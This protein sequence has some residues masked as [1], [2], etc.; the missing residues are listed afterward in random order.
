MNDM[1]EMDLENYD[2]D[3]DEL[4]SDSEHAMPERDDAEVV[5]E[6]H[7][8]SVFSVKLDPV[9]ASLAVTGGEDEKAYVWK[10]V[11]GEVLF[12]CEG[13]TSDLLYML[14]VRVCKNL[15]HGLVF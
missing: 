13:K 1:N 2:A 14:L 7:T 4:P 5:F 9:S 11:N 6:K 12:E 10:T 8:S 15:F 3:G